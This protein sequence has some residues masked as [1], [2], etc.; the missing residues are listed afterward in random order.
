M[1]LKQLIAALEKKE[2]FREKNMNVEIKNISYHSRK[3]TPGSLFVCIKGFKS[4]GH[5]FIPQAIKNGAA[6]FLVEAT[7]LPG[8]GRLPVA[9]KQLPKVIVPD[10]RKALALLSAEFYGHPSRK[11]KLIGV[12]GTNGKTT[13]TYLL[14]SILRRGG[15]KVGLLG[16]IIYRI[17]DRNILPRNT[18]PESL[19]LQEIL[20]RMSAEKIEYAVM[21]VSSHALELSRTEACQFEGAIFTNLSRDHL[22]FHRTFSHYLEVKSRLFASLKKGKKALINID[23]PH[24]D[25]IMK[26]TRARVITYGISRKADLRAEG[27]R[28]RKKGVFFKLNTP[29]GNLEI[30][31]NLRGKINVYNALGLI[32]SALE[33]RVDL[34]SI[35]EGLEG[36]KTV[37]GRMER[38]EEGQGF[39]VLIDYAHTPSAL[40]EVLKTVRESAQGRI[41]VVFGCGGGRDRGKRPLMGKAAVEYSDRVILTSDNPRN[42][43]PREIISEIEKGICPPRAGKKKENYKII[44]DRFKAIK[45]ALLKAS[46]KDTVVIAGKGHEVSQIIGDKIIPFDDREVA[47]KILG[48]GKAQS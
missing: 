45:E 44:P 37:P 43:D 20:S 12:T 2:V 40:A 47:R 46:R 1:K 14:E 19:D 38:I 30:N 39:E 42:E 5:N 17:G 28:G 41:I 25:Y 6:A 31:L 15:Y 27:L 3:V 29:R 16:T 22:D 24:A 35:K 23:D 7:S 18:T 13:T 48:N 9:G 10:S 36:I 11:L 4:D 21:E 33:E 26:K 32:V 34:K 8:R